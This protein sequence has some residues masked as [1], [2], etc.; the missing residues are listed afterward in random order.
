MNF[1]PTNN[2]YHCHSCHYELIKHGVIT[3]FPLPSSSC[4]GTFMLCI[5]EPLATLFH[6]VKQC[7]IHA[8][9]TY[10]QKLLFLWS[11]I[12]IVLAV[13]QSCLSV[14]PLAYVFNVCIMSANKLPVQSWL[15]VGSSVG[16]AEVGGPSSVMVLQMH[17]QD[18]MLWSC[19]YSVRILLW[20][21]LRERCRA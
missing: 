18:I 8:Y 15:Q 9:A 16:R 20:Y 10:V 17:L 3:V 6:V 19:W 13:Y 11:S 14:M 12:E 4:H 2:L 1:L 7:Y 21:V 5:F